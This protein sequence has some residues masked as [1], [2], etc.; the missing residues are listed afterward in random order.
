MT[1]LRFLSTLSTSAINSSLS[2]SMSNSQPSQW[3]LLI[4]IIHLIG[5]LTLLLHL[6]QVTVIRWSPIGFLVMGCDEYKSSWSGSEGV[7][8]APSSPLTTLKAFQGYATLH[9][10]PT[11][12]RYPDEGIK[13]VMGDTNKPLAVSCGGR[14]VSQEPSPTTRG[15]NQVIANDD[16]ETVTAITKGRKGLKLQERLGFLWSR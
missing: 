5:S 3:K 8:L 11:G 13:K 15:S 6:A 4:L 7:P 2:R 16:G 12:K 9:F 10:R 14:S 1:C